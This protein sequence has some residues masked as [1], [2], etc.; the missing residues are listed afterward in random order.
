M[1]MTFYENKDKEKVAAVFNS[2]GYL[3]VHWAYQ[4]ALEKFKK[5]NDEYN[6]M[7]D[8]INRVKKKAENKT[9]FLDGDTDEIKEMMADIKERQ[10]EILSLLSME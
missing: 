6:W 3:V 2:E 9:Y 4:E 8:Y 7:V 5:L 1:Y 10:E